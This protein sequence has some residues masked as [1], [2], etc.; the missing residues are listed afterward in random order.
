MIRL[1]TVLMTALLILSACGDSD[2]ASN[3]DDEASTTTSTDGDSDSSDRTAVTTAAAVPAGSSNS[4]WCQAARE[5]SERTDEIEASGVG[6]GEQF[7]IMFRDL[8]PQMRA[9]ATNAPA[10]LDVD[11]D[12]F[13]AR[14]DEIDELFASVDYQVFALSEEE[15]EIFEDERM[16]EYNDTIDNYNETVCGITDDA[17]I[18]D[19]TDTVDSAT[20]SDADIDALLSGPNRDEI[21]GGFTVLGIDEDTAECVM[22]DA[23]SQGGAVGA[24]VS[25]SAFLDSL[26]ECGMS[27]G[28]LASIGL[29]GTVGGD[30]TE[31]FDDVA[32]FLSGL[33]GNPAA[34]QAIM[35]LLLGLGVEEGA[36]QCLVDTIGSAES[37]EQ[38][39]DVPSFANLLEGCGMSLSDLI[40]L[41]G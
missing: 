1:L 30:T 18:A 33:T 38:I 21:L 26:T 37:A 11:W 34:A 36:A 28:D 3:A 20:F 10:D 39:S 2:A 17:E 13:F 40:D 22:R 8:L 23:L 12:Y 9:A 25:G 19:A 24:D 27:A 35:P 16:D 31:G 5:V 32:D 14:F 6:F 29:S 7:E 15:L 4:D 41:A